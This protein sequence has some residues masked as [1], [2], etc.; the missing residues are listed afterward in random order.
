M[1][2]FN[3][4]GVTQPLAPQH[5]E[6]VPEAPLAAPPIP[7]PPSVDPTV[8]VTKPEFG[9]TEGYLKKAYSLLNANVHFNWVQVWLSLAQASAMKEIAEQLKVMSQRSKETAMS[10]MITAAVAPMLQT[11]GTAAPAPK[12]RGRP[13][14]AK[15]EESTS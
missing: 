10:R 6:P 5:V 2:A 4:P 8:D 3:I 15:S 13:K 12:K 1:K 7:A 11:M 9:D 14:K